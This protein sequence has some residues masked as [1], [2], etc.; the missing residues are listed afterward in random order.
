[1]YTI[2]GIFPSFRS[3]LFSTADITMNLHLYGYFGLILLLVN[4]TATLVD[5]LKTGPEV[6]Q[7]LK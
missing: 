1:M 4:H 6:L 7:Q 3:T 5:L 2:K